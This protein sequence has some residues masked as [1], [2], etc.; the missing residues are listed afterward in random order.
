MKCQK[1][2]TENR[3]KARF[4]QGCGQPLRGGPVSPA[5]SPDQSPTSPAAARPAA[6]ST[7][8]P[9]PEIE[10]SIKAESD[11]Q[12]AVDGG[13]NI[14]I[15]SVHGGHVN[16][17]PSGQAPQAQPPPSPV[18][19]FPPPLP[20]QPLRLSGPFKLQLIQ[21]DGLEF[22]VR[23]LDTP[24]GEP[25]VVS[26][27]PHTTEELVAVLKAL[28]ASKYTADDFTPA[29]RGVLERLGLLH[30]GHF[31][32]DLPERVGR[33]L[34]DALM[35]GE[36][37][38]AFQMALNQARP[39]KGVV[40][41]Q[42]RFDQDAVGL[43]EYPWELLYH[44]QALLLGGVVE[45]TRYISYPQAVTPLPVSPPLRLLYI[46]SRPTDLSW[47]DRDERVVVRQ[48]LAQLEE[49]NLMQV[50]ELTRPTY[51]G[52]LDHLEGQPVHILHFD[53]HGVFARQCPE[54]KAMNYPHYTHCQAGH[55]CRQSL[56]GTEAYGYLA[57]ED[58]KTQ[59]VKWIRS[60]IIGSLLSKSSVR[61]AV[62]SACRSG[63][64]GGDVLFSG[65]APALIQAGVPAVV[66]TQLPISVEAAAKFVR[67][68]YRA[69]ARFESLPAAVNAGRLRILERE[70]FIP[71][72]Y[73][74]SQD[75]EG[76]LFAHP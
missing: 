45:L 27:L 39:I 18:S 49:E 37:N 20:D 43:A 57:F 7:P 21:R 4:C 14:Q 22:E 38:N 33:A 44:Q 71:T 76:H 58:E 69:L 54:C 24:M 46:Q 13:I 29:Q 2:G 75:D 65:T 3:S 6:S 40:A 16:I 53:G 9:L 47:L 1:C 66:S 48:A 51:E 52:L 30:E 63:S 25:Q 72:L 70:W 36:V 42:L 55:G 64:V 35:V 19:G 8:A 15:G 60:S 10:P 17:S 26:R 12:V 34:Y 62:L 68:F 11:G 23:A 67:G 28:R 74:R 61:L 73:L 56:A 32:S 50:D 31:I 59:Q 41:L 5:L